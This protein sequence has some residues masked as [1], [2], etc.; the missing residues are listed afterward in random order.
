MY[1]RIR[2]TYLAVCTFLLAAIAMSTPGCSKEKEAEAPKAPE[3][4][5]AQKVTSTAQ[6]AEMVAILAKADAYDGKTDKVV[7]K[8]AM[9]ALH[10]NGQPKHEFEIEGY[11][12]HFCSASCLDHCKKDPSKALLAL[13][14]PD[15]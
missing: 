13:K 14:I 15:K 11:K 1:A 3:A 10:M 6:K 7:S 5:I 2:S 8:C 4:S 12:M 9:C